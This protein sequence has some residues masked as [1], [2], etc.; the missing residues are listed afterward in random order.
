[1]D[2]TAVSMANHIINNII[3]LV[4][5]RAN[6]QCPVTSLKELEGSQATAEKPADAAAA[7]CCTEEE[8]RGM[9][10]S[11]TGHTVSHACTHCVCCFGADSISLSL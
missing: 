2:K 1:M 4:G 5:S 6:A 8:C 11:D 10:H 7:Y 9:P 3:R